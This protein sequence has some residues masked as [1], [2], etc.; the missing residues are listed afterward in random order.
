M[1][2]GGHDR[3]WQNCEIEKCRLHELWHNQTDHSNRKKIMEKELNPVFYYNLKLLFDL[4][5]FIFQSRKNTFQRLKIKAKCSYNNIA[6]KSNKDFLRQIK[7]HQPHP[8]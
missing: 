2:E 6:I 8:F 3:T 7:K 4:Y 5:L 1:A